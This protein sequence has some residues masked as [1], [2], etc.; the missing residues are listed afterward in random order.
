MEST[1]VDQLNAA[2]NEGSVLQSKGSDPLYDGA[3]DQIAVAL[4][5]MKHENDAGE[6]AKALK[7][8]EKWI[9]DAANKTRGSEASV[10]RVEATVDAIRRALFDF[11]N[12]MADMAYSLRG[13]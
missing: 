7:R 3:M 1:R 6:L 4:S 13:K 9:H 8:V 10:K 11:S 5:D 2:M 12:R